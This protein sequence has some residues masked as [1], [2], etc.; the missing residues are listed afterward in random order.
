MNKKLMTPKKAK[1][2]NPMA[3]N[4]IGVI[5]TT[6]LHH[7]WWVRVTEEKRGGD[8]EWNQGLRKVERPIAESGDSVGIRS[9]SKTWNLDGV[10]P[11]EINHRKNEKKWLEFE[12]RSHIFRTK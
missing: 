9:T 6:L 5:C 7:S 1:V 2:P 11:I 4:M 10:S 8:K 12:F 3:V